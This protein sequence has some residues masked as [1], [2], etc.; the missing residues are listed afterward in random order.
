MSQKQWSEVGFLT[1]DLWKVHGFLERETWNSREH[2]RPTFLLDSSLPVN[3]SSQEWCLIN[4]H[5][6]NDAGKGTWRSRYPSL[7][8]KTPWCLRLHICPM[9]ILILPFMGE[10][11]IFPNVQKVPGGNQIMVTWIG[12]HVWE[13]GS[14]I[15]SIFFRLKMEGVAQA[16]SLK[17]KCEWMIDC[18]S[19]DWKCSVGVLLACYHS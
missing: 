2:L 9:G 14:D 3:Q 7:L 11:Q 5:G 6:I 1:Q 15:R 18:L 16:C 10:L 17:Y 19:S 8:G 4:F 12:L 13:A